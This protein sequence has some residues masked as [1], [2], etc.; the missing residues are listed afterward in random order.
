MHFVLY[1][2]TICHPDLIYIQGAFQRQTCFGYVYSIAFAIVFPGNDFFIPVD[3]LVPARICW[4]KGPH[5]SC[6][7]G[8]AEGSPSLCLRWG[9]PSGHLDSV[10]QLFLMKA[11][12]TGYS[13]LVI[14][15]TSGLWGQA[16]HHIIMSASHDAPLFPAHLPDGGGLV[17]LPLARG[18]S[19]WPQ[20]WWSTKPRWDSIIWF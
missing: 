1:Q 6:R 15:T 19:H 20:M 8:M 13:L 5:Y 9:V 17:H 2:R 18:W 10:V 3:H 12:M 14:T 4:A 16:S 7:F 11:C